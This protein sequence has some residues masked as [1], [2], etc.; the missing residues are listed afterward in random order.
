M[1][2]A[3]LIG[4]AIMVGCSLLAGC[5]KKSDGKY[6]K[7]D[8]EIFDIDS[9]R[10]DY[11]QCILVDKET[12][13]QYIFVEGYKRTALSVRLDANGKPMVDRSVRK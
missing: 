2:K 5:G 1:K 13:V 7:H 3:L 12:G 10:S 6:V 9:N 4:L 8:V 11:D